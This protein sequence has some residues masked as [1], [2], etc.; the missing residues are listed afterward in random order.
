MYLDVQR[1][2]AKATRPL[3][4]CQRQGIGKKVSALTPKQVK[5]HSQGPLPHVAY[6]PCSAR[7]A[8]AS[9]AC[10]GPAGKGRWCP[11]S[12]VPSRLGLQSVSFLPSL[13]GVYTN[14][15]FPLSWEIWM[16][17]KNKNDQILILLSFLNFFFSP[18]LPHSGSPGKAPTT[19]TQR[20]VW[21]LNQKVQIQALGTT[22]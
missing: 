13:Y 3:K 12:P 7:A 14:V 22:K 16:C 19:G 20:A 17:L 6:P 21:R 5:V 11:K 4:A 8:C 1:E 15:I 18:S 2:A 10:L 9:C